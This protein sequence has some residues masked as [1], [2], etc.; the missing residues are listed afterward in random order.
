MAAA[1]ALPLALHLIPW[2]TG[3]PHSHFSWGW[4]AK[5]GEVRTLGELMWKASDKV[6]LGTTGLV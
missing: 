3:V 2:E 5:E 6:V 1:S 4:S